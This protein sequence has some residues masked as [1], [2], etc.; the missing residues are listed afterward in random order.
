MTQGVHPRFS[1]NSDEELEAARSYVAARIAATSIEYVASQIGVAVSVAHDFIRPG[2]VKRPIAKNRNPILEFFRDRPEEPDGRTTSSRVSQPSVTETPQAEEDPR[3]WA[4]YLAATNELVG[5]VA[6]LLRT[7]QR[8]A[9]SANT[10]LTHMLANRQRWQATPP[11][12]DVGTPEGVVAER[13]LA[14]DLA[15]AGVPVPDHLRPPAA[16]GGAARRS[17]AGGRDGR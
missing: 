4:G 7:T 1:E 11:V 2:G 17:R 13:D 15:A 3:F 12:S 16:K 8:M 14:A 5:D 6:E 10:R 9:A